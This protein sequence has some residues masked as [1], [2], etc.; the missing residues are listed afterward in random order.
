MHQTGNHG[1]RQVQMPGQHPAPE[2][3]VRA[4]LSDPLLTG[5]VVGSAD[6]RSRYFHL[7]Y[8]FLCAH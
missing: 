1:E 6:A 4:G 8:I 2:E 5:L 7:Q 3:Q